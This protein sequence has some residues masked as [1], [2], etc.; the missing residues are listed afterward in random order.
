M[1]TGGGAIAVR[2]DEVMSMAARL[3]ERGAEDGGPLRVS[4]EGAA[5][6]AGVAQLAAE[7]RVGGTV[8]A[9]ITGRGD[10]WHDDDSEG[11][12]EADATS[13]LELRDLLIQRGLSPL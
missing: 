12:A 7:G 10:Q 11:G 4:P 3:S 9:V 13:Y 6:L 5:V 8:V 1:A 2:S